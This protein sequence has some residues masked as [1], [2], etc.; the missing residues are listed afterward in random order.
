MVMT[1]MGYIFPWDGL[2]LMSNDH[3]SLKHLF[4]LGTMPREVQRSARSS[5]QSAVATCFTIL[6]SC[7]KPEWRPFQSLHLELTATSLSLPKTSDRSSL[8][9]L[10]AVPY[11]LT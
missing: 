5:P 9:A 8:V 1:V 7:Q 10:H 6:R 4:G 3:P 2:G 11:Q